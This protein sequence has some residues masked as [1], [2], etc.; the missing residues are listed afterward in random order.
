[1]LYVMTIHIYIYLVHTYIYIYILL[2]LRYYHWKTRLI[3]MDKF[4]PR[5]QCPDVNV[6]TISPPS[7]GWMLRRFRCVHI[8]KR[9]S[10]RLRTVISVID[11]RGAITWNGIPHLPCTQRHNN[12]RTPK[13]TRVRAQ[14]QGCRVYELDAPGLTTGLK[15]RVIG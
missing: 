3:P 1:M 12:L 11:F 14:V 10:C 8:F 9:I 13:L 7:H 15:R 2:S 5:S 4:C 6:S